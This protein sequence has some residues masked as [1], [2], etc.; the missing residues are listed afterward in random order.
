MSRRGSRARSRACR[1]R[2]RA[3]RAGAEGR[4][5][6]AAP[7][8]PGSAGCAAR[9]RRRSRRRAPGGRRPGTPCGPVS[10]SSS[11][12]VCHW[13]IASV[14]P[15]NV[16]P[17]M[18]KLP[19]GSR[20]PRCR[21]D[22]QP[23]RRPW[24]HSAARTTRSS[25]WRGFTLSHAPPRP[26]AAYGSVSAFTITP[27]CPRASA[28]SRN[29][30]ASAPVSTTA[31]GTRIGSGTSGL[32]HGEALVG[33]PVEQV[34]AVGVK[35]VEEERGERHGAPL[36][37]DVAA[38]GEPARRHLERVRPAVVAKRDRLAVEDGRA[39]RGARAPPRPPPAP[40]RSPR[41]GCA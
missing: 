31:R 26:P 40:G 3:C 18:Q 30:A 39:R 6:T 2:R 32:E 29:A 24:P 41:R 35:D 28:S 27:S 12:S 34:G 4:A 17:S 15:L 5:R 1:P 33:G 25:V 10:S 36:V 22:S 16:F 13:S 11:R 9:R 37:A 8:R 23:R 7:R 20:A 38:A 19:S 21:F 14:S